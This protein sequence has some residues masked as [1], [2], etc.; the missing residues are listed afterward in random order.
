MGCDL[1]DKSGTTLAHYPQY[2]YRAVAEV[3][4]YALMYQKPEHKSSKHNIT[5]CLRPMDMHISLNIVIT[6]ASVL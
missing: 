3:V 1:S 5:S 4:W 2:Q 6:V